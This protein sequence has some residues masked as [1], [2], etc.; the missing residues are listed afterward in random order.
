MSSVNIIKGN[1]S[2]E[3]IAND[4]KSLY[5]DNDCQFRL[6]NGAVNIHLYARNGDHV[7]AKGVSKLVGNLSIMSRKNHKTTLH[8]NHKSEKQQHIR[9]NKG[10]QN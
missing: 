9:P 2:L 6:L 1:N 8:T 5:V 7:N 3:K 4:N 10:R